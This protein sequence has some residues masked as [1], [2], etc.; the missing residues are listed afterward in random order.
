MLDLLLVLI[1][2]TIIGFSQIALNML[3]MLAL[4]N[5]KIVLHYIMNVMLFLFQL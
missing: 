5:L 2:K 3:L 4:L 1:K